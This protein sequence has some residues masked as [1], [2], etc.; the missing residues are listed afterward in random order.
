[1]T[2]LSVAVTAPHAL[3][4]GASSGIG[5]AIV[6]RLLAQ[7]WRVTGVS[8]RPVERPGAEYDHLALDIADP[9]ATEA[10]LAKLAEVETL[11]AVVHAA[12]ILR[13]GRHEEF[14]LADGERMWRLHVD[15]A[16]R[17]MQALAPILPDG[18]G[19]IVLVGSRVARGVAGRG[20]YAASKAA[21]VGLARSVAAELAP[22][23]VTVNV[24]APGATDTPMLRDPSRAASTPKLPPIGRMIRPEE[25][26]A[27]AAFLLGPDA[28]AI[29]GQ[30]IV[31]CGG[32][33]L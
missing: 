13:V 31:I 25:V 17:L 7:G 27:T 4:T 1:M 23:G 29:T 20:L 28:G 22:R 30:E 12:G 2:P 19:R 16:A 15:A 21:M 3:V 9:A 8:R 18:R 10:A 6:D 11:D 14:D 5:E 32:G 33:S 24:V 26:A